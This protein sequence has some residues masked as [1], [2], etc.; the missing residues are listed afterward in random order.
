MIID[1]F[2]TSPVTFITCDLPFLKPPMLLGTTGF[3]L[4]QLKFLYLYDGNG[5]KVVFK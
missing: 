5:L 2:P 3:Y 4:N 1:L